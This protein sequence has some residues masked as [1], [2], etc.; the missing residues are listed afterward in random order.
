SAG[1]WFVFSIVE[2]IVKMDPILFFGCFGG[3]VILWCGSLIVS[4]FY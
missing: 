1:I 2:G 3:A 4:G